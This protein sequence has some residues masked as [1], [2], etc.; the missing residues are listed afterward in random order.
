MGWTGDLRAQVDGQGEREQVRWR[1]VSGSYFGGLGVAPELGRLI[2][3]EDEAGRA[4]VAVLSYEY[5][6][7]RFG[8]DASVVGRNL[9]VDGETFTVVGVTRRWFCG[10][11]PGESVDLTVPLTAA[12]MSRL[13]KLESRSLLWV[14]ATG[15]LRSGVGAGAGSGATALCVAGTAG[16]QRAA[17]EH[18][19]A[20][21]VFHGDGVGDDGASRGVPRGLGAQW[22]EPFAGAPRADGVDPVAGVRQRGDAGVGALGVAVVGDGRAHDVRG[23]PVASLAR[24]IVSENLVLSSLGGLGAIGVAH[25]GGQLLVLGLA[26][27]TQVLL[28]LRPD[29]RVLV[30]TAAAAVGAGL[31]VSL[32]PVWMASKASLRGERAGAGARGSGAG[33]KGS[34]LCKWR[35]RWSC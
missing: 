6:Q 18:G 9:R 23:E 16:G 21:P 8:G 27:R 13:E 22:R 15:R 30:T 14:F 25:W 1:G 2:G 28:D 10:L 12:G 26:E 34:S 32:A 31:A 7:R 35:C 5:W 4:Q 20:A 3:P 33:D 29:W 24:G 17:A 19:G 11:T